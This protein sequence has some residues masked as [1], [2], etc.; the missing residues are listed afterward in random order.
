MET[1]FQIIQVKFRVQNLVP[2]HASKW[3]ATILRSLQVNVKKQPIEKI[4]G[5]MRKLFDADAR[6]SW[7]R[8]V[9]D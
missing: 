7:W 4:R 6:Q 3:T 8:D 1:H 9:Y 2:K 5:A